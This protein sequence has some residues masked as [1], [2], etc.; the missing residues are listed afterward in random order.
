[1]S[2]NLSLIGKEFSS[3]EERSWTT[4][5]TLLYALGVG[6]GSE[7]PTSE[8]A[9]TTENS[10]DTPQQVLPT[11]A[12]VLPADRGIGLREMGDFSLRQ[13]L[14]AE[15]GIRLYG[16]LPPAGSVRSTSR[17]ANMY[18]KGAN[19]LIVME[20]EYVDAKSGQPLAA[21]TTG[22]MVRG[23]G[24]FGGERGPQSQWTQ[25]ERAADYSVTY[26]TSLNQ[27]L[28]Y[29]LS[30]DRNP[31]HSDPWFAKMAG[32]PRPILHGLCTY[33]FTGRALLHL[34]CDGDP[35]R[36]GSMHV[37]FSRPVFPGQNLQINAWE[38]GD[39][40]LFQTRS[41]TGDIVIDHGVFI[42]RA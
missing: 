41:D 33:G 2:L 17:I 22:I 24:G 6:A 9:F 36:F 42:R 28:L 5:D 15:Q 39:R 4:K 19:A 40:V 1:M 12:A 21:T 35:A 18:D 30:G 31:L 11:F 10:H 14:H 23:E 37:R 8:L 38:D 13:I 26:Q 16:P 27:A 25:P 7:D 34:C 32:F 29:R 3:T 20:A